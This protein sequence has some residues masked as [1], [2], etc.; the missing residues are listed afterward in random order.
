MKTHFLKAIIRNI[1]NKKFLSFTKILGLVVGFTVFIFLMAKIQFEKSYDQFWEDSESIYRVALDVK[2]QSGEEVKSAKNFGGASELLDLELPE[3]VNHCNFSKDVVTIFNGPKKKIQDVDFIFSDPSFFDVF[4]RKILKAENTALLENINGIVI[5]QSFAK[6]LFGDENPLN[7]E[8][9]LNEGWKFVVDAVYEDVLGNSHMKIDVIATYES[10]FYY[11]KNF[12]NTTQVLVENPNYQ[13]NQP[14]PYTQRR[15]KTPVQYRPY[16]Y[17]RLKE[18]TSIAS[19]SSQVPKLLSKVPLP[20]KLKEAEMKFLFQPIKDI[21]LTSNL[22]HEQTVN[23]NTKEV[24]FL[25]LII[26][27]VLFVCLINFINLNTISNIELL[28]NYAIRIFNGSTNF[29]IFQLM[30]LESFLLNAFALLVSVP[31]AYFLIDSQLTTV[32][33]TP[34]I[35]IAVC[36]IVVFNALISAAVPYVSVIKN[37][38][39]QG[40]KIS[41]QKINLKWKS[42]KVL[43]TMQFS[44]TI[45]LIVCTIGIYKQMQFM[46]DSDLGFNGNQTL[47][48]FTPMTMNQHPELA[49]K[50]ST[51]RNEVLK[52]NGV[53]TFSASSSIPGQMVNRLNNQVKAVDEA[54][55]FATSFNEISIDDSYLSTYNINLI[56]GENLSFQNDW[57]SDEI[58]INQSALSAMGFNNLNEALDQQIVIRGDNYKIKGVL[59]DYHHVSLHN[60]ISPTLYTQNLKWDH[61]VGFYSIQLNSSD[62]GST[63]TQVTQIWNSLYPKEEFIYNF[64]DTSFALQYARDQKFNQILTYSALLALLISCLGLLGLALFNTKKRVKE[65]GIRKVLG[66]SVST[67]IKMLVKDFFT[68]IIIALVIATPLAYYFIEN[69]LQ[70]F[71]Y[72]ISISWWIFVI[73]GI[74]TIGIT[75]LTVS[76]QAIKAATA[77][78]VNALRSE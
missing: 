24:L 26:F 52:L 56:A 15:W 27:V 61:S 74:I 37:G 47:F 9:T 23:G 77:N 57:K 18:G 66:A 30:L 46:M 58:I 25:S 71:A 12:D 20:Q 36:S 40:L 59:E 53:N 28:K 69:W 42:Q 10:L 39:S 45:I 51:F 4:P 60:P 22:E 35:L 5:S 11:M 3:V 19:I 72:R 65:I 33:V 32:T 49:N 16:A 64:S 41:G 50:L 54:E 13:F 75:L 14:D 6:K 70:D 48:S 17:I 67:V 43:V 73:A 8:I 38:F 31:L 29:Q 34:I 1:I 63:M 55:P 78:P 76:I 2:Y 7:K 68:L 44:I 21:H 62:I